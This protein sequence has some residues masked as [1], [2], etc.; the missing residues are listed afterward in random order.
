MMM[1]IIKNSLRIMAAST[2]S[3]F[4]NLLTTNSFNKII[5]PNNSKDN[6]KDRTSNSSLNINNNN[7]KGKGSNSSITMITMTMSTMVKRTTTMITIMT[8]TTTEVVVSNPTGN[9]RRKNLDLVRS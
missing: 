6:S 4:K 3:M 8:K 5:I 9:S 2:K 7:N 1:T